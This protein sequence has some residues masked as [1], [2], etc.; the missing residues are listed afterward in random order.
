[1]L[2]F[3]PAELNGIVKCV[4]RWMEKYFR[5]RSRPPYLRSDVNA[6]ADVAPASRQSF[7][8]LPFEIF[9]R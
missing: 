5:L 4:A 3:S 2:N 9:P 7:F 6:K 8:D 1:M